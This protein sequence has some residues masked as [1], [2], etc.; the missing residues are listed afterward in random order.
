VKRLDAKIVSKKVAFFN[1][2][3]Y[4]ILNLIFHQ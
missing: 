3:I 4:E 2:I 1:K